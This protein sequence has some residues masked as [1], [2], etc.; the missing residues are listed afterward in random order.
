MGV[1]NAQQKDAPRGRNP[2]GKDCETSI[3]SMTGWQGGQQNK[4]DDGKNRRNTSSEGLKCEGRKR[5]SLLPQRPHFM[6]GNAEKGSP[7]LPGSRKK[8]RWRRPM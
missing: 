2:A 1:E 6:V 7:L 3:E 5:A 8:K 4:G